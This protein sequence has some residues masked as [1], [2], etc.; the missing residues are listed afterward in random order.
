LFGVLLTSRLTAA[1][2]KPVFSLLF[3]PAG[4]RTVVSGLV[5][6]IPEAEMQQRRVLVVANLKPA[7]MRG[8]TSQAMVLA[9]THPE[10][11]KVRICVCILKC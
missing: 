5:K 1:F 8:I 3:L 2:L 6:H 10:S 4:P 11:G 9:A 7:A